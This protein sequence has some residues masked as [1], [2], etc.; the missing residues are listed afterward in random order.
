MATINSSTYNKAT[1]TCISK[2]VQTLGEVGVRKFIQLNKL[3]TTD[4]PIEISTA[5]DSAKES[6]LKLYTERWQDLLRFCY[7][8]GDYQSACILDR[9]CCPENPLPCKPETLAEYIEYKSSPTATLRNKYG[10]TVPALDVLGNQIYCRNA[11]H[12]PTPVQQYLAAIL[13]LH[14]YYADL[15]EGYIEACVDCYELNKSDIANATDKTAINWKSCQQHCG[16]PHIRP[17]GNPRTSFVLET[18]VKK[19]YNYCKKWEV[20][21]NTQFLPSEVRDLR[22]NLVNTGMLGDFELYVMIVLGIK[23]FLRAREI[24]EIQVEDFEKKYSSLKE[25]RIDALTVR[26]Q[27]KSDPLPGT[28]YQ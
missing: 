5:I 9:S 20:Q 15:R 3:K 4:N 24:L 2:E 23:L 28:R 25:N 10:T 21:G 8:R 22:D 18:A 17:M 6:T 12:S 7:L 26:V 14:K 27:G 13:K 19:Y 11:W 1:S 16:S